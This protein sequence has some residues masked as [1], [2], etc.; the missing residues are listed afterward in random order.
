VSGAQS[1]VANGL[2]ALVWRPVEPAMTDDPVFNAI[3]VCRGPI[4][5]AAEA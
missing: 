5:A 1:A 4:A 3:S 2:Q